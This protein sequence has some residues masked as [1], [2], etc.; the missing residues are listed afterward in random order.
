MEG[1]PPKD[2][3]G[4]LPLPSAPPAPALL[5]KPKDGVLPLAAPPLLL[6]APKLKP[7]AAGVLLLLPPAAPLVGAPNI[8]PGLAPPAAAAGVPP[9]VLPPA[10]ALLLLTPKL[11]AVLFPLS[12]APAVLPPAAAPLLLGAPKPNAGLL[13]AA[14][15]DPD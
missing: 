13:L 5:P 4:L 3:A 7:P 6:L 9:L 15:V 2:I 10:A 8:D 12:P 1:V 11:K 14:A